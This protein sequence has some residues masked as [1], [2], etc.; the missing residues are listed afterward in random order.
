MAFYRGRKIGDGKP[1]IAAP[2]T[3]AAM[4]DAF[5]RVT[6]AEG[7]IHNHYKNTVSWS[8]AAGAYECAQ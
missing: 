6:T 4:R 7:F 8:C 2:A 1:W 5:V 3:G